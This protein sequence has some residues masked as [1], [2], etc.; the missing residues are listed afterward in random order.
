[1]AEA[2]WLDEE[3]QRTWRMFLVSSR[4]LLDR[5]ERDLKQGS[6]LSFSDYEILAL[7]SEAPDRSI[8]MVDLAG[9]CAFDRSRLS[10]AVDRLVRDGWVRR[11]PSPT[12]GRGQ[13][14][15]LTDE[16]FARLAE[17]APGHVASVRELL[18][19]RLTPAQRA[20]LREISEVL[21]TGVVAESKLASLG[22]PES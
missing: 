1:M 20:A 22:W 13:Y 11:V 7:L 9:R 2:R 3:E 4:L 18:I 6:R 12:D 19:D 17:A 16:G 14:A 21:V 8:R 15:Q 10:H 5:L